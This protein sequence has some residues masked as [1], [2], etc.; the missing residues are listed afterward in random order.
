MSW[1]CQVSRTLEQ[2]LCMCIDEFCAPPTAGVGHP[3]KK[4]SAWL[5]SFPPPRLRPCRHLGLAG[6]S[7]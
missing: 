3:S 4:Y 6:A 7:R 5:H 1:S 2:P